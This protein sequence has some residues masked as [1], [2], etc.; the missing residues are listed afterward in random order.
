MIHN[1]KLKSHCRCLFIWNWS[2]NGPKANRGYLEASSIHIEGIIKYRTEICTDR[3][4]PLP[5][6]GAKNLDKMPP[7]IQ[8]L[9]MRLLRL[10]ID[11]TISHVPG[12][13]LTPTYTL[14]RAPSKSTSRVKQE[15]EI[16]LCV[17]N[18]LLQLSAS[19][20][21]LEKLP[22]RKSKDQPIEC[23]LSIPKERWPDSI[24]KVASSHSPHWSSR[25]EIS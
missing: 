4:P 16:E 2:C 12:K 13:E 1:C 24:Q 25:G 20:K 21:R 23:S 17:E 14:S 22:P 5:L 9:R 6:L 15:E 11:F 10:A 7:R 19:D 18:I 8:R 3:E